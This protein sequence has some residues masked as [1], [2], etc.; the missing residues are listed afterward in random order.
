MGRFKMHPRWFS[1]CL[2]AFVVAVILAGVVVRAGEADLSV[3]PIARDGQVLVSFELSDGL[4]EDVR[5]AIQSG[6]PTTFSYVLELRRG[7]AT[8]FDRTIAAVTM[9]ATVRFDNLTRR[10]QMSRTLDGRVEDAR[11]TEDRDAVRRWMTRF[12]HVPLLTTS[13][14]EANGEYYVRVRAHAQPRN[15]WFFWPWGRDWVLGRAKFT[16][17]P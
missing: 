8:W 6:L 16:F 4:T 9:T 15:T 7:T 11:P 1:S 10:Y 13:A 5:D 3:L 12:E 2:R 14:L 17:I